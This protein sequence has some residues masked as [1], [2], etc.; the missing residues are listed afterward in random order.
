MAFYD[1]AIPPGGKGTIR[2]KV[3]TRNYQGPVHKSA[4][5]YTNDPARNMATIQVKAR[6]KVPIHLSARYV[7]LY[8]M[9]GQSVTRT[10]GLRAELEKPLTLELAEFTLQG[11]VDCQI[12]EIEKGRRFQVRLTN[13][14]GPPET[15][16]GHLKLKTNYAESPELMLRIRGR[17]AKKPE[18]NQ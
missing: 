13:L 17:F 8:G 1:K 15:Y 7:Y 4:R 18:V 14:P 11:K 12:Q 16:Q 3:N 10:V 6:I 5:V 2:L 9:E